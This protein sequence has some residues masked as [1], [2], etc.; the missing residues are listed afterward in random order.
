[1]DWLGLPL[2]AA[3]AC[4]IADGLVCPI[5]RTP[6]H[7]T[8]PR[9][10]T[11]GQPQ[12]QLT[13]A[14][15]ASTGQPSG[16]S[17][18]R[19]CPQTSGLPSSRPSSEPSG[20]PVVSEEIPFE[21]ISNSLFELGL[22]QEGAVLERYSHYSNCKSFAR[23][24][25]EN[26][27]LARL[28]MNGEILVDTG[29]GAESYINGKRGSWVDSP[30]NHPV[31]HQ[32]MYPGGPVKKDLIDHVGKIF[33]KHCHRAAGGHG[34]STEPEPGKVFSD[35][36]YWTPGAIV[37][38]IEDGNVALGAPRNDRMSGEALFTQGPLELNL[39]AGFEAVNKQSVFDGIWLQHELVFLKV[40]G[41]KK[42]GS[43]VVNL[44][45]IIKNASLDKHTWGRYI[46]LG[47]PGAP[48]TANQEEAVAILKKA[49]K[50]RGE[51]IHAT[52]VG[53]AP[54]VHVKASTCVCMCVPLIVFP[55]SHTLTP[56]HYTPSLNHS[57]IPHQTDD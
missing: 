12:G 49:H 18:G 56:P 3:L 13:S 17:S 32:H 24:F 50:E 19:P 52:D 31:I 26:G 4:D 34:T 51:A 38:V 53:Q 54:G 55:P 43:R 30:D 41:Q 22:C 7:I 8:Q 29:R 57:I 11:S 9:P 20:Q 6:F 35:N 15:I 39:Q 5:S 1:M 40:L 48:H 44:P 25:S 14:P 21:E 28:G 46:L 23:E 33:Y 42:V 10:Q 16:L 27:V 47:A 2:E 45:C 37:L 36:S